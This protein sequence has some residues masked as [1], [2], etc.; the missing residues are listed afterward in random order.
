VPDVKRAAARILCAL[1][2]LLL[3][4]PL[5]QG[6]TGPGP[7]VEFTGHFL[8]LLVCAGVALVAILLWPT[9]VLI[10]Y[11][12]RDKEM[13]DPALQTRAEPVDDRTEAEPQTEPIPADPDGP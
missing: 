10:R 12:R 7:G 3:T 6:Y 8:G 1:V 11:L 13:P 5:A 4:A 2:L 9:Y